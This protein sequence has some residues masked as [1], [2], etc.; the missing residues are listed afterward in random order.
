MNVFRQI[1][2]DVYSIAVALLILGGLI[3]LLLIKANAIR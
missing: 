1:H 3:A 2:R